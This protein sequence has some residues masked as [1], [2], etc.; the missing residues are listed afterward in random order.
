MNDKVGD[1]VFYLLISGDL[2]LGIKESGSI[3]EYDLQWL[4][5]NLY[6]LE[7]DKY[8]PRRFLYTRSTVEFDF[9]IHNLNCTSLE[10]EAHKLV[11]LLLE[12][13]A[14]NDTHDEYV[15]FVIPKRD[16]KSM[17]IEA[18]AYVLGQDNADNYLGYYCQVW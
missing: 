11:C 9:S 8:F 10:I 3:S 17:R 4:K 16:N 12:K 1:L 5:D 2:I 7:S 13:L 14:Q 15:I 18:S 6:P